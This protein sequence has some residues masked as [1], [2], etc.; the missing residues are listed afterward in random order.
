MG[1]LLKQINLDKWYGV[2][3]YLGML[4]CAAPFFKTIDFLNSK[5]LFG[6]GIGLVVISVAN[7]KALCYVQEFIP[8]GFMQWQ[9]IIHTPF[10]KI[11][12]FIG[13]LLTLLFLFLLVKGLI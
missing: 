8:G 1:D 4:C 2:T 5:H 13:S 7:F 6:L 9:E 10:T 11:L 3:L 12:L